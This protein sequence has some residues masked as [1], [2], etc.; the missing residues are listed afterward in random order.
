M[1]GARMRRKEDIEQ[2]LA[3]VERV[4]DEKHRLKGLLLEELSGCQEKEPVKVY[5][6]WRGACISRT[7]DPCIDDLLRFGHRDA[8]VAI[9]YDIH[10]DRVN[11]GVTEDVYVWKFGAE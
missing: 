10:E 8:K 2:D 7:I 1:K 4:L 5:D 11:L 6:L 3:Q 9:C